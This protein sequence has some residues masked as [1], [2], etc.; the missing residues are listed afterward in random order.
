MIH[1]WLIKFLL[2]IYCLSTIAQMFVVD[3][4]FSPELMED[5]LIPTNSNRFT[6]TP[7]TNN[8][9]DNRCPNSCDIMGTVFRVKSCLVYYIWDEFATQLGNTSLHGNM[10][11]TFPTWE[12][13]TAQ[14]MSKT[15]ELFEMASGPVLLNFS[16]RIPGACCAGQWLP[17]AQDRI[18]RKDAPTSLAAATHLSRGAPASCTF[19]ILCWFLRITMV[20]S[21]PRASR[22]DRLKMIKSVIIT[23]VI[24]IGCSLCGW[25]AMPVAGNLIHQDL[26]GKQQFFGRCEGQV[27]NGEHPAWVKVSWWF[28][29]CH[30]HRQYHHHHEEFNC[31]HFCLHSRILIL[32]II[33]HPCYQIQ[34]IVLR[35]PGWLHN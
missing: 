12:F 28:G 29:R 11:Q 13:R 32:I 24:A 17:Q 25:L 34:Y 8:N 26:E 14:F 18:S 5:V 1:I 2:N 6:S 35:H 20:F 22:C 21:K 23:K 27:S 30:H 10:R 4:A 33:F 7:T 19:H 15:T 3:V 9:S 31:Y 16:S